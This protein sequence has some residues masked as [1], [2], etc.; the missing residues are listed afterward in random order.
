MRTLLAAALML[1]LAP[2]PAFARPAHRSHALFA[3]FDTLAARGVPDSV[4][5]WVTG[6]ELGASADTTAR[7]VAAAL[8]ARQFLTTARYASCAAQANAAIAH[9]QATRDTLLECRA[10]YAL[11]MAHALSGD[12]APAPAHARRLVALAHRARLPRDEAYGRL[13]L[14]YLDVLAERWASAERGYRAALR[15]LSPEWDASARR[16]A[17]IGLSRAVFNQGHTRE[18]R[19]IDVAIVRES[20][21]S[22]DTVNEAVALNNLA[23][24]A[25]LGGDPDDAVPNWRRALALQR[26]AGRTQD[27]A[28]TATNLADALQRLG[29]NDEACAVL[30]EFADTTRANLRPWQRADVLSLLAFI[31]WREERLEQADRLAAQAW[32]LAVASR[33]RPS[34]QLL[35]VRSGV[36][37]DRGDA[38]GAV[39]MLD[40]WVASLPPGE[41]GSEDALMARAS[42]ANLLSKCGRGAEA[43]ARWEGI[44]AS[45]DTS[46]ALGQLKYGYARLGE[47]VAHFATGELRAGRAAARAA[48]TCWEKGRT[49][50]RSA[51]WRETTER[52]GAYLW[53]TA[54]ASFRLTLPGESAAAREREAFDLL[55][56]TKART[57]DERMSE[58]AATL[59]PVTLRAL[60]T[61]VLRS[62]ELA[63][64][65]T[66]CRDSVLVCAVTR[67]ALRMIVLPDRAGL[68]RRIER[69]GALASTPGTGGAALREEAARTLADELLGPLGSLAAGSPTILVSGSGIADAMPWALLPLPAGARTVTSVPSLTALAR[70]RA[71]VHAPAA[72]GPLVLAGSRGPGGR[73]LAGVRAEAE[74]LRGRY[75]G[76]DVRQPRTSADLA[77]ALAAMEGAALVHVAAHF[78]SDDENPWQSGILLGGA[79]ANALWLRASEVERTHLNAGLVVLAGCRSASPGQRDLTGGRG[80][81]SAF[82]A[83]GGSCVLATLWP[84]EDQASAEFVRQFYRAL[85][86]GRTAASALARAQQAVRTSWAS[87][88][89]GDD[90][91]RWAGFVLVG[92]PQVRVTSPRREGPRLPVMRLPGAPSTSRR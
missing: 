12:V 23:V 90:V 84:V 20:R 26:A 48:V 74:F 9:A 2:R 51:Q 13:T 52:E 37:F 72:P 58:G 65:F 56:R 61:S 82:L 19:R 17:R 75:A 81:S 35:S 34:R 68:Q 70:I 54:L 30:E 45:L 36:A 49:S 69:F 50:F 22:G 25:L 79:G 77:R 73:A 33:S 92:D 86:E 88:L 78:A 71:R 4:G 21:E 41:A 87:A 83:A 27:A 89:G 47:A 5:R 42:A 16:V 57:F 63:L 91:S 62:G 40:A 11:A 15:G 66:P 14:A 18:A 59:R 3:H 32:E 60:Q 24:H 10:L 43:V 55:Q 39:A 64:D 80:M 46:S 67:G 44:T 38:A 85:D 53:G 7:A 76:A 29:R 1:G 28:T 8:R 31:R 6:P